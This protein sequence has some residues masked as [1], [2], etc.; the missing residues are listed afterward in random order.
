[1]T[2]RAGFVHLCTT[3]TPP[4][5]PSLRAPDTQRYACMRQRVY[6][7][8]RNTLLHTHVSMTFSGTFGAPSAPTVT[9]LAHDIGQAGMNMRS[10]VCISNVSLA[11]VCVCVRMLLAA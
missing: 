5:C 9:R 7:R 8:E 11:C 4:R 1:M 3:K 2:V 10:F 6:E